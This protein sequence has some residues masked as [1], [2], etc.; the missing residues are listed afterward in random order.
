MRCLSCVAENVTLSD[1]E[2]VQGGNVTLGPL[3]RVVRRQRERILKQAAAIRDLRQ[4]DRAKEL[5]LPK[6]EVQKM[7]YTTFEVW[8]DR[9]QLW[10]QR[11][12][13]KHAAFGFVAFRY[14]STTPL[15][16]A[17]LLGGSGGRG[18]C[19][20]ADLCSISPLGRLLEAQGPKHVEV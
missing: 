19:A 12:F 17:T 16:C 2:A 9:P 11:T 14:A 4:A 20:C 7:K 15:P 18:P 5:R 13:R 10:E 3:E 8:E 1:L 6:S